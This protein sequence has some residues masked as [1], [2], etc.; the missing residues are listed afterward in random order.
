MKTVFVL[1]CD[2]TGST[3]SLPRPA[4]VALTDR[5]QAE[6]FTK[7][8]ASY[9]DEYIEVQIPERPEEAG[10]LMEREFGKEVAQITLLDT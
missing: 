7:S 4:G 2:R 10:L 1:M 5:E 6:R 3:F 9:V 8:G